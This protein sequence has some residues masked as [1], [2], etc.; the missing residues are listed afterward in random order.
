MPRRGRQSREQREPQASAAYLRAQFFAR[1]LRELG[2]FNVAAEVR[3]L[4]E[5]K[6]SFPWHDIED[7][8]ISP[9]AFDAVAQAGIEPLLFFL[10]PRVIEEQPSLL[11]YYRSVALISQKGFAALAG[12]SP[13]SIENGK[14]ARLPT[15][16]AKALARA[17]NQV[18]CLL[19]ET[20]QPFQ[21]TYIEIFLYASAGAQVQGSWVN[22][23]GR[24]G[25]IFLKELI[26]RNLWDKIT[27]V[28]WKDDTSLL[29]AESNVLELAER[30]PDIK[31]LRLRGGFHCVFASEPDMSFR[32]PSGKPMIAVEV[33]AGTDPAGALERY[34]A[35]MKSF[36]NEKA[37]NP[38]VTTVYIASCLTDEVKTRLREENPFSYTFILGDLATNK[39]SQGKLLGLL[40]K[41]LPP[42]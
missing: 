33:K 7:M 24:Q 41:H 39:R 15:K 21:R 9:E 37:M 23:I 29:A 20:V 25:E 18:L 12:V 14:T 17:V 10:H 13:A 11:L 34:G 40:L 6:D 4:L 38:N 31:L 32:D 27:Q 26:V 30:A 1:R 22:A 8:G 35:A 36:A 3:K 19:A 16:L 5:V 28:V 42:D 2:F